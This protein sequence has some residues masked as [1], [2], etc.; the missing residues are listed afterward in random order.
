VR[1]ERGEGRGELENGKEWEK[2]EGGRKKEG[3]RG[4][5]EGDTPLVLVYIP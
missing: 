2:E 4:D 5:R 3:M 1:N